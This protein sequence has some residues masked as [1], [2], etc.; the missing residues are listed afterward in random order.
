MQAGA[1]PAIHTHGVCWGVSFCLFPR[2]LAWD[3]CQGKGDGGPVQYHCLWKLHRAQRK[4]AAEGQS[5]GE[6]PT[7][8]KV[9]VS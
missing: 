7:D 8:D 3:T 9:T 5:E 1:A 2:S 6:K 4:T